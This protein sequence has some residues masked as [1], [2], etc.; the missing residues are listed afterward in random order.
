MELP[1]L[2]GTFFPINWL[3]SIII[4][5]IG[6]SRL[7]QIRQNSQ[8]KTG[9]KVVLESGHIAV[10]DVQFGRQSELMRYENDAILW[11]QRKIIKGG[12]SS[13]DFFFA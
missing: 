13:A 6:E 12:K 4:L 7:L 3:Q 1:K 9:E 5:V 10:D 11:I 8:R 2:Q